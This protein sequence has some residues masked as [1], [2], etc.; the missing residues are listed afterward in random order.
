M[1]L[2]LLTS[3]VAGVAPRTLLIAH[4]RKRAVK[5]VAE[6]I[7]RERDDDEREQLWMGAPRGEGG[8]RTKHSHQTER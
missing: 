5:A 7:D 8:A 3:V 4:P 1:H 2:K 6:P